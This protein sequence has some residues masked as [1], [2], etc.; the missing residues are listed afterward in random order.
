MRSRDRINVV[1]VLFALLLGLLLFLD[2]WRPEPGV[3]Q[4]LTDLAQEEINRIRIWKPGGRDILLERRGVT[5]LLREPF[6]IRAAQHVVQSLLALPSAP[7]EKQILKGDLGRFGLAPAK[8]H[9]QLNDTILFFGD[10]DPLGGRRYVR[11]GDTVHLTSDRFFHFF[12]LDP[13]H[14]AA[15]KLLPTDGRIKEIRTRS[16][17]LRKTAAGG[18]LGLPE[19]L[20]ADSG[21]RLTQRWLSATATTTRAYAP[22]LS[23]RDSIELNAD[24][25][26][27]A[28]VI[29]FEVARL[30]RELV[31][32]RPEIGIQ[33]HLPAGSGEELLGPR[34]KVEQ[35]GS[36]LKSGQVVSN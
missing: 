22:E 19:R 23:W 8:G 14:F 32:G 3:Q 11:V 33:Y 29:R 6:D 17:H 30:D 28:E 4:R 36:P 9:I 27:G 21:N 24:F 1:L 2:P 25:G 7:S 5:W 18:W 15:R 20:G 31:F 35:R 12:L 13:A 16:L 34:T 26:I 10:I